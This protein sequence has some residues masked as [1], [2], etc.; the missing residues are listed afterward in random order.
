ME[1]EKN[2]KL[3]DEDSSENSLD[4]RILIE[5]YLL[6]WKW[7]VLAVVISLAIAFLKL[8]F[9]RSNYEATTIIK[10]KDEKGSDASTLSVFQ[11]LGIMGGSKDNI[12]DEMEILKS[13]S[14]ISQVVKSLKLNVQFFTKKNSIS[15]FFDEN[16][17]LN[18]EFY[19]I[20]NYANPPLDI[21]F[22]ISDSALYQ[23]KTQFLITVNSTNQYTF[24][25]IE[26]SIHRKHAFGE[27]ITTN[28]GDI[29]I[30]PAVDLKKN[31]LLGSNILVT[32]T[33]VKDVTNSY[34]DRLAIEPKSEFS[35][36]LSLTVID[37]VKK[38]AEDFLNELV[39][40]YNERAIR[41]KEELSKSTSDFVTQ[42]L[43]I[44]SKELSNVDLTAETFKTRNRL[45]DVASETGLNIQSGQAIENQ[46]IESSTQLK[47]IEYIKEFVNTKGEN[48]LIPVD[49]GVNNSNVAALAQ[50]YNELMMQ[51]KRILK[52][53]TEKNPIVV[54]LNEQL[55]TLKSNITQGLENLQ[56]SQQISLDA[57]SNQNARIN[58][59]LY[60]APKQ[61]RQYRDIQRQQGIKETLYLY[62]LQKREETAITL[63]V[64][65]PNAI[66]I[67]RAESAPNAVAPKKKI[68]LLGAIIIGLLIPFIILY[69]SELLDTKIHTRE[70]VEKVL[71][72]PILGDIPKLETKGRYLIKKDDYSSIAE[73]FRILRTNLN[74]ILPTSEG[75]T[76]GKII[77]VTSTIAHEGKS[78]VSTNLAAS[79]AH[80]GK[81]TVLL[82][83]D[84]RAP[85]IVSYLNVRGEVGVTNYIVNADIQF[86]DIVN[87][88]PDIE[89]LDVISSGDLAP[90]PSELLMNPKVKELFDTVKEH[91]EYIIVDTAAFSMVTDTMLLSKFAD[92]YIYV[93]RMNFLDKRMLRYIKSLYNEKRLPNMNLLINGID[94]KKGYGYGYGYGYGTAF[95]KSKKPWWKFS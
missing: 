5:K 51:K 65:D 26:K 71:N 18:T 80:A 11:D 8:N 66:I 6:H 56:S 54:N 15:K 40:K 43:E 31:K 35:N 45:S 86:D 42:R 34:V 39:K 82:G 79:L 20:E 2:I 58:S 59:K 48:Q 77:F 29:T 36:V 13:K 84:I 30:I 49:V 91:Y 52:N 78:L 27:R 64:V 88:V 67:D 17:G 7:F 76:K 60:N 92:A 38:R 70:A 57:L 12:E 73:A 81:K 94:I 74:F 23:A 33:P 62:L 68:F 83:M 16:L 14:L 90:N 87:H 63:G 28:F 93:I 61:E 53:S 41:L 21:N 1:F 10:I 44:I 95:E 50:N 25:D 75:D 47:K 22:F 4:L 89:N 3:V 32:I 19:E 37:G 46:I 72:I 69:L 24:S 55:K 9:K 85:K